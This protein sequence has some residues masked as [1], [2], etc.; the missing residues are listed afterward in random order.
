M[1]LPPFLLSF[2][3]LKTFKTEVPVD[4]FFLSLDG[5]E[6]PP[7]KGGGNFRDYCRRLI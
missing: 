1:V 4:L 2:F 3:F 6:F 5:R 7:Y